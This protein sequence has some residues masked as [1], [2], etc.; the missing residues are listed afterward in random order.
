MDGKWQRQRQ[1]QIRV[2][3]KDQACI[4]GNK[5][6]GSKHRERVRGNERES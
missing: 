6:A 5:Q 2:G 1:R 4:I 3:Q